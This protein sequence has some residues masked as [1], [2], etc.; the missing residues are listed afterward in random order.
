MVDVAFDHGRQVD[1]H[2]W[3]GPVQATSQ[4]GSH[5]LELCLKPLASRLAQQREP[6]VPRLTADMR[7]AEEQT[8]LRGAEKAR[9]CR[10][11]DAGSRNCAAD[12][13]DLPPERCARV[14]G[15]CQEML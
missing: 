3:H 6:P 15:H 7:K 13:C 1:S 9:R 8:D 12:T 4:V 5:L 2:L 14:E 10:P 11:L